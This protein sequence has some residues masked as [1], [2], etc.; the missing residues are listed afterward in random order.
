MLNIFHLELELLVVSDLVFENEKLLC[1]VFV[2]V[3]VESV[4]VLASGDIDP[5]SVLLCEVVD[6]VVVLLQI[7]KLFRDDFI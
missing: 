1:L 4:V 2:G 7:L 3:E 5:V 6:L